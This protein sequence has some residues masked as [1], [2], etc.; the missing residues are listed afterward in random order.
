MRK[1]KVDKRRWYF[2]LFNLLLLVLAAACGGALWWMT[3]V[4]NSLDAARQWQGSS[5]TPFAQIACFLPEDGTK[6]TDEIDQF[7]RTLEQKLTEASLEAPKN[8]S[9]YC[10]AWSAEATLNVSGTHG[11]ADVKTVGVGGN[12]FVF[13]PLQLRSGSYLSQQDFMQ[14]RVVL[15]EITA[16]TLFGSSDVEGMSVTV[17]GKPCYV[18]G[19]IR[20]EDDFASKAAYGTGAGMFLSYDSFA[21]LKEKGITCYEI[22]VPNL[23]SGFGLGLVQE[24]FSVGTGDIVENSARYSLKNLLRVIGDFG[25]RSM[26][27]N[28][29]IYPYWENAVRMTEDWAALLLCALFALLL[30][31][32]VTLTV[33]IIRA[34]VKTGKYLERKVPDTA[35]AMIEKRR[36]ERWEAKK[37]SGTQ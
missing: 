33:E 34:L 29:V 26:R 35:E 36:K 15:D 3:G 37:R 9:L 25:R 8:G 27:N 4:L 30:C 10:D 18:A 20:R 28:G 21:E 14:D 17:E 23:V 13:H 5:E 32:A 12:F 7:R 22:V 31:P 11:S 1:R 6:T 19:V 2:A 16:W 24:N